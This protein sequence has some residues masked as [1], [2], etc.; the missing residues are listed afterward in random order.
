MVKLFA[1]SGDPD[2]T[3]HVAASDQGLHCLPIAGSLLKWAITC[4][5]LKISIIMF[6]PT[7]PTFS[8][9]NIG[10]HTSTLQFFNI[11]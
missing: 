11:M 6:T 4:E 2:Q 9:Y 1:N 7:Y 3:L 10:K 8:Q 5:I